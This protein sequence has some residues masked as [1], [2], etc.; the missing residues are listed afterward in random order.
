[1]SRHRSPARR[2]AHPWPAPPATIPDAPPRRRATAPPSSGAAV[3][4][5]ERP[6]TAI[7]WDCPPT[8]PT[9]QTGTT[10]PAVAPT[11]PVPPLPPPPRPG[12]R[13][14][15]PATRNGLVAA[16]ATAGVLSSVGPVAALLP[17]APVTPDATASLTLAAEAAPVEP[18]AA[19]QTPAGQTPTGQT[20]TGLTPRLAGAL[21]PVAT[22]AA[23]LPPEM[24][25]AG[26][27]KAVGLEDVARKAE[28][29]RLAREAAARC[30]A[31]LDGLGR[32]K[33]WVRDAA[34]FLSCLYERPDVLGVGQ[35]ARASDH[36]RGLAVDLMVRGER[37]DRI[38]ECALANQE[39]FGV[40]YVIWEQRV[41]Y[42]DGWERMSDRGGDTANHMDHVHVSFE[43]DGGSGDAVAA[44]CT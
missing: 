6:D 15:A 23:T 16:V 34:Q 19:A 38:A 7:A 9:A 42:G 5:L 35:R 21:R 13:H 22:P 29:A 20:P 4:L 10:A 11:R 37:G 39:A 41:N 36:P 43:R 30:D 44:R 40:S 1:M 31:D 12:A 33:P 32:V 14:T 25:A 17:A 3:A 24:D 28:E 18:A 2:R 27:L 26:L 8:S